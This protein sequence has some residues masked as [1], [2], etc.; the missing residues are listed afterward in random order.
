MGVQHACVH[1]LRLF[2]ALSPF[3]NQQARTHP[4]C[5]RLR[6][7][8]LSMHPP[9]IASAARKKKD[10][11]ARDKYPTRRISVSR[12]LSHARHG[13]RTCH[14]TQQDNQPFCSIHQNSEMSRSRSSHHDHR[15][16]TK[17]NEGVPA[18]MQTVMGH[19]RA[20]SSR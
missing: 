8:E 13:T 15:S 7:Q 2:H 4:R 16:T 3:K 5:R 11:T 6:W 10:T 12:K 1:E 18:L 20:S 19:D 9:S 17:N 14:E